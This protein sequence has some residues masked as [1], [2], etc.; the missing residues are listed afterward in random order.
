MYKVSAEVG[1]TLHNSGEGSPVRSIHRA[2]PGWTGGRKQDLLLQ[3][4]VARTS[5]VILRSFWEKSL[6][7]AA[8]APSLAPSS[9]SS[10]S[11]S[12]K[13]NLQQEPHDQ[14]PLQKFMITPSVPEGS[15]KDQLPPT[16]SITMAHA[17]MGSSEQTTSNAVGLRLCFWGLSYYREW[18]FMR[19]AII[20]GIRDKTC[21]SCKMIDLFT[22]VK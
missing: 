4:R 22:T 12:W 18:A 2:S 20:A 3:Q 9:T 8:D 11:S 5:A 7:Q 15:A 16:T 6:S 21:Y 17:S 19:M 13:S 14:Q 10:L 1:T